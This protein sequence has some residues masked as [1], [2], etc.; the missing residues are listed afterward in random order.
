VWPRGYRYRHWSVGALLPA[1]FVGS[2][3]F[4]SDYAALGLEP[5]P[6]GCAWVRYGPDLVLVNLTTRVILDV[7]YGVFL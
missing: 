5:P 4:Y 6:P 3:Y 2:G 7:V 1:L